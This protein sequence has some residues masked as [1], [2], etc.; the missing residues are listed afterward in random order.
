MYGAKEIGHAARYVEPE[1]NTGVW[2]KMRSWLGE[3]F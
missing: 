3:V 2:R 1:P